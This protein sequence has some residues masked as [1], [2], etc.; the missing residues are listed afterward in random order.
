MNFSMLLYILPAAFVLDFLLGDPLH[1]PHPV[2]WMGKAITALEPVFRKLPVGF[3]LSGAIFSISLIIVAWCLTF[4][5]VAV[6]ET[7]HPFAKT[8]IEIFIIYYSI[9]VR[10][11]ADSAMAVYRSLK[12]G[13]LHQAKDRLA[14]IV[15]RDVDKLNE[16]QIA[17]AAVET[18]AEN[19]VDGVISPLFFA[20][21]GGAP[22]AMAFKMINTLDSMVG[23]KN[24]KYKHFGKPSAR[25]DDAA[26][27]FPSRLSIFIIAI[28]AQILNGKGA[29][30]FKI[31]VTDGANHTS[32]NA[33]YPE[34]AFAGALGVRLG[35]PSTY[36]SELISKPYIGASF[37]EAA[38]E[39]I[40]K[41]CDL[42]MLSS[43]IWLGI[44]WITLLFLSNCGVEEFFS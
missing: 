16:S 28:A 2:R 31:A 40:K 37:A 41:S 5:L 14:M 19:L 12:M 39:H 1:F 17:Q 32:P 21:I 8:V 18:V 29:R 42:M 36:N 20:A 34:S 27:F 6:A 26:N 33:G 13:R 22:M 15:G 10:S 11:L 24:E 43:L 3:I 30:S 4:L 44:L 25:I 38:P 7:I 23:Y 35:G 9:S